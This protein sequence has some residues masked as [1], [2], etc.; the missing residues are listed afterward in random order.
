[1]P[2]VAPKTPRDAVED[3]LSTVP[4]FT[5]TVDS[6]GNVQLHDKRTAADKKFYEEILV[7]L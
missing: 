7:S 5:A 2:I 6:L 3:E 4:G 1:M